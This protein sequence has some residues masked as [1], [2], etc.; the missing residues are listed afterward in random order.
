MMT[1][2]VKRETGY[3]PADG[4]WEYMAL[5]GSGRSI[6]TPG[7]LPMCRSCHAA[8]R[9]TDYLF[10]SYLPEKMGRHLK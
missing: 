2:M 3:D 8:Q 1:A 4:D 10:R 6:G 7:R 9:R 5:D